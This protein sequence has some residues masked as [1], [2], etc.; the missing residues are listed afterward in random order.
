M[1]NRVAFEI[2]RDMMK[3]GSDINIINDRILFMG[4][5]HIHRQ[6]LHRCQISLKAT[7]QKK[8][9]RQTFIMR[10]ISIIFNLNPTVMKY[11]CS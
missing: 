6:F 5:L 3:D 11:K 8:A 1:A 9:L 4:M 7:E 10:F 2:I